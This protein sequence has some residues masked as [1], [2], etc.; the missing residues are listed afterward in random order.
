MRFSSSG[1]KGLSQGMQ[2]SVLVADSGCERATEKSE[3]STKS[4]MQPTMPFVYL[5]PVVLT[6]S[7]APPLKKE[8]F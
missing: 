1:A 3:S 5:P 6:I 2:E 4:L 7:G 8:Q